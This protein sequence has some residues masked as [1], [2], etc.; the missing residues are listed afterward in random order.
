MKSTKEESTPASP[1]KQ[2]KIQLDEKTHIYVVDFTSLDRWLDKYPHA[3][4][5]A[6]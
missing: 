1:P 2:V 5:V 4:V 6:G 3:K